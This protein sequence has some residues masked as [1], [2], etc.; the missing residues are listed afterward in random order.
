MRIKQKIALFYTGITFGILFSVFCFVYIITSKN[1]DDSFFSVLNEK[2]ITSAQKNFEKDELEKSA[3][4]K[5]LKIYEQNKLPGEK[6]LIFDLSNPSLRQD[7]DTLLSKEDIDELFEKERVDFHKAEIQGAAVFYHDNEGDFI[8]VSMAENVQGKQILSGLF[9]TLL[10]VLLLSEVFVYFIGIF[11]AEQILNPLVDI[12]KKVNHIRA[13]NL[14]MRLKERKGS[15]ELSR[16]IRLLNQMIERLE[17][18]FKSQKNFISNA[19]HELNNPLT[20]ILGEVEITLS[21]ERSALEYKDALDRIGTEAEKI[22]LLTKDLLSLAQTDLDISGES[23]Q[24]IDISELLQEIKRSFDK[25]DY[26]GRIELN[27]SEVPVIM[28]GNKHL[29]QIALKNIQENA[30]KY[31]KEK[32][33][34]TLTRDEKNVV[35][36]IQDHG[37]GIPEEDL[38]NVLQPF[39]RGKNAFSGKGHGIG[40]SL[41]DRIISQH[42][43]KTAIYSRLNEGTEVI[44]YLPC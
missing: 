15:D 37:I 8:V 42:K 11:Y 1:I 32:V 19:S 31:S 39:F 40:L 13:N 44:V 20:A 34:V 22:D 23:L 3:Y 17:I 26:N 14:E 7:L 41:A 28:T 16:L 35:I 27:K 9:K 6:E 4:D 18:T 43:G 10:I 33:I 5:V 21:K 25:T 36:T 38:P 2:V 29:L 30:C 24:E 12:L